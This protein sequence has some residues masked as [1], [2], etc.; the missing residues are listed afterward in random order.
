M[1]KIVI[2]HTQFYILYEMAN[3]LIRKGTCN[4]IHNFSL[5]LNSIVN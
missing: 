2:L 3:G 4:L 1:Y 5:S